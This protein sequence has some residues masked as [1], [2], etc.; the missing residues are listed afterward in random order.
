MGRILWLASYPKS[1]NTWLRAFLHNYLRRPAEPYDINRLSDFTASENDAALYQRYDPRPA[2]AYS[3]ESVQQVRP[4][5]HRDLT[6]AFPDLVFVKTHNAALV[7]A[8]VPL[9]TPQHTAGSLYLIRDPRDVALSYSRH[10]GRPI[11]EI[12]TF[13][14][15]EN[16]FAGGDDQKVFEQLSS[17]SG[18]V[19]SWTRNPPRH[20]LALRYEDMLADPVTSFSRLI[21][22]LGSE[23]ARD[24]LER[25]IRDSA[26]GTLKAQEQEHGFVERPASSASFF[27]GGT[28]GQWRAG[29]SLAQIAR[30]EH[31]H[32]E[33]M[34]RFGY[35]G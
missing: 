10:L 31:D 4:L 33:E 35:L 3:T 14:A 2:S 17:W 11:D 25:A 13:M 22:F 24:R 27:H 20:Q 34:R 26:F 29:L 7:V 32:G 6:Q 23:P 19:R 9:L 5:V 12:I 18:H 16:A 8:G 30:I 28:A 1:G 21:R 15:E